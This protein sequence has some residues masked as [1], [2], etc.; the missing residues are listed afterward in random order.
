MKCFV[1]GGTGFVGSH[2][3]KELLA[4]GHDVTCYH[5][6]DTLR[7]LHKYDVIYHIAGVL[8][9]PG[10]PI[11]IYKEAHVEL[12]QKILDF[13]NNSQHFVYMSTGWVK[14]ATRQYQLTKIAGENIVRRSGIPYTIVRP[15]F[16]YGDGDYHHLPLFRWINRLGALCPIIGTGQNVVSPTYI[17][18]VIRAIL[19]PPAQEFYIASQNITM[20]KFLWAV[21]TALGKIRPVFRYNDI[22]QP[23]RHL[24]KWDFFTEEAI[25]DVQP[26]STPL[27]V[28]LVRTAQWY[29]EN[30]L[31]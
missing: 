19:N 26:N 31:L 25:F 9:K 2:L 1:T 17:D 3:V 18:D 22:P 6:G 23:F 5:R 29:K 15:G 11:E 8:G 27:A 10:T 14:Y 12:P 16:I 4:K 7:E 20:E 28:G 24:L 13:M 21:A 30:N